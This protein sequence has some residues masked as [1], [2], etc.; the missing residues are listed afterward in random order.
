MLAQSSG[1]NLSNLHPQL[2]RTVIFEHRLRQLLQKR[3]LGA[4][5]LRR[6][7]TRQMEI[8]AGRLLWR[9]PHSESLLGVHTQLEAA[10]REPFPQKRSPKEPSTEGDRPASSSKRGKATFELERPLSRW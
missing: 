4:H 3:I 2:G 10:R 5:Q 9:A 8:R 1:Y 7:R 6:E